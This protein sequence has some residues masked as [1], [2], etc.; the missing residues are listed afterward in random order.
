ML[1]HWINR[2]WMIF[3]IAILA[4]SAGW[5]WVSR[6][7]SAPGAAAKPAPMQGFMAPGFTSTTFAGESVSLAGLKGKVVLLNFWASWCPPCRAEMQA[8]QNAYAD[9]QGQGLVVLAVNASYQD[10]L[11]AATQFTQTEGLTFPLLTDPDGSINRAYRVLALPTTFFIDRQGKIAKV[12]VG[13]PMAEALVRSEVE[14]LLKEA[15]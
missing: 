9:D 8:I 13:G 3:S 14:A 6:P 5:V 12:V 7:T 1:N 15:P 2:N 11:Q 4:L 10:D